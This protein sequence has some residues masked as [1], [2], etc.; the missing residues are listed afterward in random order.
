MQHYAR[1]KNEGTYRSGEGQEGSQCDPRSGLQLQGSA[2]VVRGKQLGCKKQNKNINT[3]ECSTLPS[4]LLL[5][6]QRGSR[7]K[8]VLYDW[9][10]VLGDDV[11][12]I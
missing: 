1:E 9:K 8:A 7:H 4:I 2:R 10:P 11:T 6:I 12:W 3:A 5:A